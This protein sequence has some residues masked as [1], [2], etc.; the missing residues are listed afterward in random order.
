MSVGLETLASSVASTVIQSLFDVVSH[1]YKKAN[2]PE[3][4]RAREAL[5]EAT[6]RAVARHLRW[7]DGWSAHVQPLGSPSPGALA[8]NTVAL[9]VDVPRRF[10]A[11][12]ET[13]GR[14]REHDLLAADHHVLLT[15]DSGAGKTTTVKRLCRRLLTEEP[16]AD[17]DRAFYPLLVE[18]R[19]HNW[20]EKR[21]TEVLAVALGS[22]ELGPDPLGLL[23]EAITDTEAFVFIDGLDEVPTAEGPD[24]GRRAL[25]RDVRSL[26]QRVPD[27]RM[28]VSCRSGDAPEL[29]GFESVE[30]CP[31]TEVQRDH[32]IRARLGQDVAAFLGELAGHPIESVTFQPLLLDHV[33]TVYKRSGAL[34]KQPTVLYEKLTTLL[35]EDWD[36][37]R[38][39][40]R[41]SR[42]GRFGS[43]EKK[44]F[45]AEL[46]YLL[47]IN[48]RIRFSTRQLVDIYEDISEAY[49]LPAG[50]A[51]KVAKEIESHTGL[52]VR[53][54][55]DTFEFSHLSLQEYLCADYMSRM[56]NAR[57]RLTNYA[58]QYPEPIA[59]ACALAADP[60]NWLADVVLKRSHFA[61]KRAVRRFVS[62][63]G[64]ERPG[65]RISKDLGYA[66]L[67]LMISMADEDIDHFAGL[68]ETPAVRSGLA[69]AISDYE[70]TRDARWV[71]V[72]FA[73]KTE[74]GGPQ[75]PR[76]GRFLADLWESLLDQPPPR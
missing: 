67:K 46:S 64:Q 45:L 14:R 4:R 73:G 41:L 28:L 34:P 51:K 7:V 56:S 29:V 11:A 3:L 30:I 9:D 71:S 40:Q 17:G 39:V 57:Q 50:Q 35:L 59:I 74:P 42:Y 76:G 54:G 72:R 1:R 37:S 66:T 36:E 65:F 69:L 12:G 63:L 13:E 75:P 5:E 70:I 10:R 47:T 2:K 49:D 61:D 55:D 25:E 68:A 16:R 6:E 15:G 32:I 22:P 44:K 27:G 20:A 48:N 24:R 43:A 58:Q 23:A 26:S 60:S 33:I 62:R 19:E 31:L 18:C 53:S 52:I 38:G 21:L 8:E